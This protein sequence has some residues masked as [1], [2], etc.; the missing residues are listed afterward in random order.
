MP[1]YEVP[2]LNKV[3]M[4]DRLT[5]ADRWDIHWSDRYNPRIRPVRIFVQEMLES[6][7]FSCMRYTRLKD[8]REV[9]KRK[10]KF[11]EI[12]T[13]FD[14][15]KIPQEDTYCY[16]FQR[17]DIPDPPRTTRSKAKLELH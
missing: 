16:Y 17:P 15:R 9:Y 1:G 11:H 13:Y 3:L 5:M 14:W 2:V 4:D 12:K 6:L 8:V 7:G 10:G